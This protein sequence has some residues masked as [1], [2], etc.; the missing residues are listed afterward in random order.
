[1]APEDPM[2]K[3][4][5]LRATTKSWLTCAF[6]NVEDLLGEAS[7]DK[8]DFEEAILDLKKRLYAVE[9]N[10]AA[11]EALIEDLDE[12]NIDLQQAGKYYNRALKLRKHASRRIAKLVGDDDSSLGENSASKNE[13]LPNIDLQK[14]S[15]V[16]NAA[17][18]EGYSVELSRRRLNI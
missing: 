9:E 17:T 15:C 1:M 8:V 18:E 7:S 12:L 4:K 14:F 5:Q 6:K 3:A 13:K 11:V 2:I 16:A 10:Q